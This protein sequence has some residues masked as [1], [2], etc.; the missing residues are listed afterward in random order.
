MTIHLARA[1]ARAAATVAEYRQLRCTRYAG[2]TARTLM[3]PT[4][5]RSLSRYISRAKPQTVTR[6]RTIGTPA[7]S[8]A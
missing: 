4:L 2:T 6:A 8:A 5:N 3:V 1:A 7:L